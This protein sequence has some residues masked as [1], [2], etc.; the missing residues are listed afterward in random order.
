MTKTSAQTG[1]RSASV[2][3]ENID[4]I[5]QAGKGKPRDQQICLHFLNG[6]CNSIGKCQYGRKHDDSAQVFMAIQEDIEDEIPE[7]S[8]ELDE[9]FQ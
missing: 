8:S 3:Q 6:K 9:L 2:S 1:G 4:K 7:E 5:L